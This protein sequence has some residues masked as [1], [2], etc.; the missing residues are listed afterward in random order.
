MPPLYIP[1]DE[2]DHSLTLKPNHVGRFA[3]EVESLGCLALKIISKVL[4]TRYKTL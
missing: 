3:F 1:K 4:S 2:P